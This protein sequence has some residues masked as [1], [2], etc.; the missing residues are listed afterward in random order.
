MFHNINSCFDVILNK[1]ENNKEEEL[2]ISNK[3]L[4]KAFSKSIKIFSEEEKNKNNDDNKNIKKLYSISFI[5]IFLK[6]FVYFLMEGYYTGKNITDDIDILIKQIH[7]QNYKNIIR[8]YIYKL[9]FLFSKDEK[10]AIDTEFHQYLGVKFFD[11]FKL[12]KT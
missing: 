4:Y 2:V 10:K 5:K 8:L 7:N 9:F 12:E 6:K 11:K 3:P 1:N